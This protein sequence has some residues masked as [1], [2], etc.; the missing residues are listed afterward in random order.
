MRQRT[1]L[2]LWIGGMA[3]IAGV[4]ALLAVLGRSDSVDATH[5]PGTVS[6]LSG[7]I[8][9]AGDG[10]VGSI[11]EEGT[12]ALSVS[13]VGTDP[14]EGTFR[15]HRTAQD[16]LGALAIRAQVQCLGTRG[17]PSDLQSVMAGPAVVLQDTNGEVQPDDWLVVAIRDRGAAFADVVNVRLLPE[18][19]GPSFP[20]DTARFLCPNGE[21]NFP[22]TVATGNFDINI[23]P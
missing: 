8:V 14:P 13:V 1:R 20:P 15:Y 4:V 19:M 10:G 22:A 6:G 7:Q 21:T 11:A 5:R 18:G 3:A 16:S 12:F 23:F 2:F 17:G 9:G